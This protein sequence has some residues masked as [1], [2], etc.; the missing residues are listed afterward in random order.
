MGYADANQGSCVIDCQFLSGYCIMLGNALVSWKT[1]KQNTINTSTTKVEYSNL[2]TT[3]KELLLISYI[4]CDWHVGVDDPLS[5]LCDNK[6]TLQI[7]TNPCFHNCTKYIDIDVHFTR[8]QAAKS[9]LQTTY[10]P[11]S[12]QLV[13]LFTKLVV[14][15]KPWQ[16]CAKLGFQEAPT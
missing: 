3:I 15:I 5:L 11:S 4:L 10:V 16:F 7:T 12:M 14:A 2:A 9:V 6:L 8:D 13:H 1:K